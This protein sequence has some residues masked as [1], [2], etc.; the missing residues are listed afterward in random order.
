MNQIAK[1]T[2]TENSDLNSQSK[3]NEYVLNLVN[4]WISNADSK[5]EIAMGIFAAIFSIFSSIIIS[6][7]KNIKSINA[8]IYWC[9]LSLCIFS[10]FIFIISLFFYLRSLIP[11]F[12]SDKKDIKKN[13]SIFFEEIKEFGSSEEYFNAVKESKLIDYNKE[14]AKEIYYN[15]KICSSKMHNFKMG[16][17]LSSISLIFS[18]IAFVVCLFA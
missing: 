2:K 3:Q 1:N 13:Y 15:S 10:V 6:T 14:L 9:V 11:H 4:G 17:I 5:V 16:I 18:I 12:N 8:C 7:I